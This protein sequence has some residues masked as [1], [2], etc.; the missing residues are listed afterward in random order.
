[1]KDFTKYKFNVKPSPVDNRDLKVEKL[2]VVEYDYPTTL[3]WRNT[4]FGVRDQGEQGSCA[5]MAGATMKDWQEVQDS[6]I[7][8]YM[9]PQF[10]YNNRED[11]SDEGM[12]MR[13]LMAI[14]L[15]KGTCQ[16][17]LHPY[18]NLNTPSTEAYEDAKKYLIK[19][20]AQVETIEGLKQALYDNGPC[21]L[22]VPV[23]NTGSRMWFQK[24]GNYFLGGHAMTIVGYNEEGFIVRNS[25]GDDWN[26][27]GYT[28]FPYS[29]WGCQWEIW[30]T[31]DVTSDTEPDIEPE[32]EPN[33]GCL[34]KLAGIFFIGIVI[35]YS[36][37]DVL[38]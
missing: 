36:L 22:A 33:T 12:V 19:G 31:I 27:G 24:E 18:G 23:Y 2:K 35:L 29:D 5:A 38:F 30:S 37:T 26:D 3:D 15:K 34:S 9:S 32:P 10:I 28:I 11:L 1:M 20:Y 16:E 6:G 4:M 13:D 25:W 21:I 8:D 14:L 7:I 17:K